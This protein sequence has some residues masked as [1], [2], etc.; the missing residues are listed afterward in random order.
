LAWI[1]G[2]ERHGL[3]RVAHGVGRRFA[4]R[5]GRISERYL[6]VHLV[7]VRYD[8][9]IPRLRDL[10]EGWWDRVHPMP[11]VDLRI[12]DQLRRLAEWAD[13]FADEWQ[14]PI[15]PVPG[16]PHRYCRVNESYGTGDA[17]L[18]WGML[19]HERPTRVLEL[20][21]GITTRLAAEALERNRA[22]GHPAE[23]VAV[24]PYPGQVTRAGFPG[25]TRLLAVPAQAIPLEQFTA[26]AAGDVLLVDSSHMLKAGSDVARIFEDVLPI[27]RPG[28]LVHFH[29]IYLPRPYPQV[30]VQEHH[31][32]W[33]EQD[34]LLLYL[35]DNPGWEVVW[36][37]NALFHDHFEAFEAAV[38]GMER[39]WAGPCSFWIRRVPPAG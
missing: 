23:L 19:R 12:D 9:P 4:E 25:L 14:F 2:Q 39:G 37:A 7:P 22:D 26:L 38:P 6:G 5:L 33:N 27:L 11:G 36:S 34:A 3:K 31:W 10:P 13:R 21:S 30:V 15:G 16:E 35:S 32:Y 28:V 1:T 17:E 29:D 20:G 8:D 24:D 18:L